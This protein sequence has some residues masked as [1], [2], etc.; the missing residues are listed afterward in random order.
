[1]RISP[2]SAGRTNAACDVSQCRSGLGRYQELAS[3][4][5]V[6]LSDRY[7]G[8]VILKTRGRPVRRIVDLGSPRFD[9]PEGSRCLPFKPL[10]PI[11]IPELPT[12][13][14][15]IHPPQQVGEKIPADQVWRAG[16]QFVVSVLNVGHRSCRITNNTRLRSIQRVRSSFRRGI[17]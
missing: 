7:F 2:C 16:L 3:K 5:R 4:T 17:L 14:A 8:P 1:M 10:F 15:P 9:V 6:L 11:L 12:A 13:C